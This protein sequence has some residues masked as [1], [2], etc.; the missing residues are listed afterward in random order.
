MQTNRPD[1]GST[2]VL[3]LMVVLTLVRFSDTSSRRSYTLH[4]EESLILL[5][6]PLMVRIREGMQNPVFS[7]ASAKDLISC[8]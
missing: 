7:L 6:H 8:V 2:V 1:C 3:M 5:V 4:S